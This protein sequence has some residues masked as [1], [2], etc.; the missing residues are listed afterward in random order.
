MPLMPDSD[1]VQARMDREFAA[2]RRELRALS[3]KPPENENPTL[4]YAEAVF[5]WY[6]TPIVNAQSGK[7]IVKHLDAVIQRVDISATTAG[8]TDSVLDLLIDGAVAASIT[9]PANSTLVVQDGLYIEVSELAAISV[10]M[11]TVGSGIVSVVA[12]VEFT[13]TAVRQ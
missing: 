1:P 9:I 2:L 11:S 4:Y 7:Y 13:S 6:G 12:T 8:T 5:S 3:A 10:R